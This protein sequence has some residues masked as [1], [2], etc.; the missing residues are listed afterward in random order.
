MKNEDK[1]KYAELLILLLFVIANYDSSVNIQ[2]ENKIVSLNKK[3]TKIPLCADIY[4]ELKEYLCYIIVRHQNYAGAKLHCII[5]Q[6]QIGAI[7]KY[8][9]SP[10]KFSKISVQLST[11]I[12]LCAEYKHSYITDICIEKLQFRFLFFFGS[13]VF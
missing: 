11:R 6:L 13:V 10:N 2:F 9:T 8:H 3:Y 4:H 7:I 1:G 5:M 12:L